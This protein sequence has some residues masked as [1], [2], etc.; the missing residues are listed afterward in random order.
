MKIS[1]YSNTQEGWDYFKS[2]SYSIVREGKTIGCPCEMSED[3]L[4]ALARKCFANFSVK[5]YRPERSDV[6]VI[7]MVDSNKWK[8]RQ[9]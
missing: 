7:L 8:F 6:D 9:R 4:W 2:L 1:L 3:D 5:M